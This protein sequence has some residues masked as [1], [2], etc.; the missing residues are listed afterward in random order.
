[1]KSIKSAREK[2]IFMPYILVIILFSC[3]VSV[4]SCLDIGA[5][6]RFVLF[7]IFGII[8]PGFS[9]C[10]VLK[11]D[12]S[13]D[14]KCF[15]MSYMMGYCAD[16]LIYL[17]IVPFGLQSNAWKILVLI[18]GLLLFLCYLSGGKKEDFR[19]VR[20]GSGNKICLIFICLYLLLDFFMY[21]VK[22]AIPPMV[23]TNIVNWDITYW[24]GNTIELTKE[25]PPKNFRS[26]PKEYNYHYF[27]SMQLALLSMVTRIRPVI[28]TLVFQYLQPIFL[29]ISGAYILFKEHAKKNAS[30]VYGIIL[31]LFSTGF[32]RI[33]IVTYREHMF[34]NPFGFDYGMGIFLF[35]LYFLLE[36]YEAD[37]IK[38]NYCIASLL[39]FACL[40]GTK[41]PF[42]AIAIAGTGMMSLAWLFHKDWERAF[43]IGLPTLLIFIVLYFGVVNISGYSGGDALS[44]ISKTPTLEKGT[45]GAVNSVTGVVPIAGR[46]MML[47]YYGIV[48]N[49]SIVL[50]V[51]FLIVINFI[52]RRQFEKG[53]VIFF[54]M[55]VVA[56]AVSLFVGM[57]GDSQMYFIMCS[58]PLAILIFVMNADIELEKVLYRVVLIVS[59]LM[60]VF[61][62]Y[63]GFG[64]QFTDLCRSGIEN[65]TNG[66]KIDLS[67]NYSISTSQ[68]EAYEWLR[69]HSE[70][71]TQVYSNKGDGLIGIISECYL[72]GG[73]EIFH[74]TSK[75]EQDEYIRRIRDMDC[76]YIIHDIAKAPDFRM[77]SDMCSVVFCNQ[78]TVI[79]R[80]R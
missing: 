4:I 51:T 32:E 62:W 63:N 9:M 42:A 6:I 22:N 58:F 74:S 2:F 38:W 40:L 61:N 31:L 29:I 65:L 44:V 67:E 77:L 16:M 12:M 41:A 46:I 13:T 28:V 78:S 59:V 33:S 73:V 24:T 71:D 80:I 60:G 36:L 7:Q 57:S 8:V 69:N 64:I 66:N 50:V 68:M 52:K 23:N 79:Y 5:G 19:V 45:V 17:C 37:K 11:L 75:V 1:M 30:V 72:H 18:D 15:A 14:V 26:Y 49:P 76:T 3:M 55:I 10:R 70:W 53:T 21:A 27:S 39:C 47:L 34:D 35:Y 20:D 25:F 56:E 43:G 48:S 54:I